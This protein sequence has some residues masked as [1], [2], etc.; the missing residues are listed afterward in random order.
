MDTIANSAP[1]H[2]DERGKGIALPEATRQ[3]PYGVHMDG[4]F[5]LEREQW[6][7]LRGSLGYPTV[8]IGFFLH[9]IEQ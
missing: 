5:V 3:N 6:K 4:T 2:N 9:Q 1:L 8:F 7:P